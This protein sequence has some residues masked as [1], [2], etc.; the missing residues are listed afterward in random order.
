MMVVN[1]IPFCHGT[2]SWN[3]RRQGRGRLRYE[4][5]WANENVHAG[6]ESFLALD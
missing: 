2:M 6:D 3:S 1:H 5:L 4:W